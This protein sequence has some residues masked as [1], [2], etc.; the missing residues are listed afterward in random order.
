MAAF[1][2]PLPMFA[3][4]CL[5]NFAACDSSVIPTMQVVA[6]FQQHIQDSLIQAGLLLTQLRITAPVPLGNETVA[7]QIHEMLGPPHVWHKYRYAFA[8]VMHVAHDGY[9]AWQL[10]LDIQLSYTGKH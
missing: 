3:C 10:S 9:T 6:S 5:N 1:A 4:T 2:L 7:D 8:V